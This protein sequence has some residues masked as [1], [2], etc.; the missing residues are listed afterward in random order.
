LI[1]FQYAWALSVVG[2]LLLGLTYAV[3]TL[4]RGRLVTGSDR[5][6]VSVVESA[7]VSQHSAVHVIKVGDRYYLVG[8]GS[9]G[10]THIADV[11]AELVD[12]YIE[13]QRKALG[14][15]RDAVLRLL[16]RFRKQP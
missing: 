14:E 11:P 2:L 1:Y 4:N 16:Q 9:A 7:A 3:R 15:Q 10:V 8:G 13:T 12:P 5:R 6:L